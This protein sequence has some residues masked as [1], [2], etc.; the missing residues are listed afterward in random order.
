MGWIEKELAAF[1]AGGA[2]G[3]EEAAMGGL[4]E[5]DIGAN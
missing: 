5:T 4:R 2:P 1:D 3:E